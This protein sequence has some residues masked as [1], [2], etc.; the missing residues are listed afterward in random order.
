MHFV[1]GAYK[2]KKVFFGIDPFLIKRY[3]GPIE[4]TYTRTTAPVTHNPDTRWL[5]YLTFMQ[6]P[7]VRA[8]MT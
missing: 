6:A 5:R 3:A 4:S 1:T 7:V 2:N 8:S